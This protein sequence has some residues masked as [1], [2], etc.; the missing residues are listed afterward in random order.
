MKKIVKLLGLSLVLIGAG[1]MASDL[2]NVIIK[3]GKMLPIQLNDGA[4]NHLKFGE[5]QLI[6]V[7]GDAGKVSAII[8]RD[9]HDLFVT[10]KVAAPAKFYLALSFSDGRV[11]DLMVQMRASKAPAI[12]Q[13]EFKDEEAGAIKCALAAQE[14][15]EQMQSG[16]IGKY[17]VQY[18]NGKRCEYWHIG[19]FFLALTEEYR[20]ENIIGRR[21]TLPRGVKYKE[22]YLVV[23]N[24][25]PG[26]LALDLRQKGKDM[27]LIVIGEIEAKK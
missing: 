24:H 23:Q 9:N 15:L 17:Y 4:V 21:F 27:E 20:W 13:F 26:A 5:A 6:K 7:I 1:A 2:E 8:G 19:P 25:F 18:F 16:N 22:A 3:Q 11:V 14:M 10:S 12:L